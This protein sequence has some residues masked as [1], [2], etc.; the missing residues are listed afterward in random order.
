MITGKNK[1]QFEKWYKQW[2]KKAPFKYTIQ[3]AGLEFYPMEFQIGVYLAYYD[4]LGY[5]IKTDK[6]AMYNFGI[7][8]TWKLLKERQ[9]P[10]VGSE[11]YD[12]IEGSYE[13]TRNEAYKE[14]FKKADEIINK[15]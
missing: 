3:F 6:Y 15:I 4:S 14:A 10:A 5:W 11:Y 7:G 12:I 2:I 13:A 9:N 1:E 8:Y